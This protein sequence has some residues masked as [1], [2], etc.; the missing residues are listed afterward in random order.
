MTLIE[1]LNSISN[2]TNIHIINRSNRGNRGNET[3]NSI[4]FTGTTYDFFR[5]LLE[6]D[7]TSATILKNALVYCISVEEINDIISN[8]SSNAIQIIIS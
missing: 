2:L 4:I 6:K 3:G 5:L 8:K 7:I 1:L